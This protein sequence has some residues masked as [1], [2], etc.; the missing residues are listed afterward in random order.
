MA[1]IAQMVNGRSE[2]LNSLNG[3]EHPA[4]T[5]R[6]TSSTNFNQRSKQKEPNIHK[7]EPNETTS[8]LLLVHQHQD[9]MPKE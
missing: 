8:E 5:G 3:S 7:P 6:F 1:N 4:Q 2:I 9:W